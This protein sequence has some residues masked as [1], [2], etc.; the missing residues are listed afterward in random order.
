MHRLLDL[1]KKEITPKLIKEFNYKNVMEVPKIEKIVL[2]MGVGEATQ[3][4]KIL[5]AATEELTLIAGQKAIIRRAKKSVATFKLREGMPIGCMVTLRRA[6]M[7]DFLDKLVN[8]ALPRVKDFRGVSP[9]AF[10]GRGNYSLGIR[11]HLIFPE[12][13]YDKVEKVKGIGVNIVTT[14]K[15][16]E[17]AKK[18][19]EY[20]GMPF[21]K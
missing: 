5:D 9:K 16:D 8:I 14:A 10:D 7:Y 11:E 12:L 15:T 21:R 4:I 18:L 1:Y 6:K 2:N 3:N 13:D 17:E 20:M 19:L